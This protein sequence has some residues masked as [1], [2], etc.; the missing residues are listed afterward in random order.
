MYILFLRLLNMNFRISKVG[1]DFLHQFSLKHHYILCT[2]FIHTKISQHG[3]QST[4]ET[5]CFSLTDLSYKF[6][7]SSN[8]LLGFFSFFSP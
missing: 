2:I 8:F 1:P 6:I 5:G 3:D 4:T 7:S